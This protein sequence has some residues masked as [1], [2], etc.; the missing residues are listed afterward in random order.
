MASRILIVGASGMLGR[1][2]V[3]RMQRNRVAFTSL[4]RSECD[5]TRAQTLARAIGS[6]TA[7]VLNC[8]GYTD[9]A[10]A[11]HHETEAR[12]INGEGVG[13]L[14]A[15]CRD[16][17]ALLVHFSTDYVFDG[18]ATRPYPTD[19]PRA[20]VNAYGRSKAL[21][22][23]LLERSGARHLLVRTSW[24]YAPWGKNFVRTLRARLAAED[25]V[26]VVDDQ[27]GC[28]TSAEYLAERTLGLLDRNASGTFHV[29]DG[30]ECTWFGF[31]SRIARL[32]G[33][34]CR[35]EPCASSELPGPVRPA[36]SVLDRSR[37][38]ALLGPSRPWEANLAAVLRAMDT[39]QN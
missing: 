19:H 27:T 33:S 25:T 39:D 16:V 8:A 1:A 34:P 11:E 20:A 31:A 3:E 23:E 15:R 2:F 22:E 38:E 35:V 32:T 6:G 24:L 28:P 37:T 29:T 9:V 7:T 17:G 18:R 10:G 21:G 4:A 30:G 13:N 36:Y 12:A 5:L 14:A 26:R